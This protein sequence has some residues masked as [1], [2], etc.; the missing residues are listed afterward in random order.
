VR[1]ARFA[2]VFVSSPDSSVGPAEAARAAT[3]VASALGG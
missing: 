2:L 1:G 3:A